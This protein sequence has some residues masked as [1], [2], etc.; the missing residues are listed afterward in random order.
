M[1]QEVNTGDKADYKMVD[2]YLNWLD[3]EIK[4]REEY[5]NHKEIMAWGAMI[6]YL[7]AI[8]ILSANAAPNFPF[9]WQKICLAVF[10]VFLSFFAL[11]FVYMQFKMRW[12]AADH[13]QAQRRTRGILISNPEKFKE[14]DKTIHEIKE[15]ADIKE[16]TTNSWPKFI[17]DEIT[18]CNT[19]KWHTPKEI[20]LAFIKALSLKWP[21][22]DDRMKSE[23]ACYVA[24]ISGTLIAVVA[25]WIMKKPPSTIICPCCV[26]L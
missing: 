8:C 21:D 1:N 7:P 9:Y 15:G 14:L 26:S 2:K 16:K 13:I 18:K 25:L 24:L 11:L 4:I 20:C 3:S 19:H 23:V 10:L 5:H 22:I 12:E 17:K 6:F